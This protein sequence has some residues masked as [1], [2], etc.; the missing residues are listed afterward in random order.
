[1]RNKLVF[2][3]S[4]V[5]FPLTLEQKDALT[6]CNPKASSAGQMRWEVSNNDG[7]A[8]YVYRT[9]GYE[10]SDYLDV[11]IRGIVFRVHH[12]VC[13]TFHGAPEP[14]MTADH[15]YHCTKDNRASQLEWATQMQQCENRRERRQQL[16]LWP[17]EVK[18][19]ADSEWTWYPSQAAYAAA[20]PSVKDHRKK[21]AEAGKCVAVEAP[22]ATWKPVPIEA[23]EPTKH[24]CDYARDALT[25]EQKDAEACRHIYHNIPQHTSGT[26]RKT[27]C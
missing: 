20:H 18:V 6:K 16:D 10:K 15:K 1:M 24:D 4:G 26:R 17:I 5:L 22:D 9:F 27:H 21:E 14:G 3:T 23:F 11:N 13:W 2:V 8:E 19:N 25:P 12:L 7:H